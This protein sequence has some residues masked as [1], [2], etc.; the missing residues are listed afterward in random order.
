MRRTVK[1]NAINRKLTA[2][3]KGPR[4]VLDRIQIPT[5]DWFFSPKLNELYHYDSGVFEA[6]PA[7]DDTTFHTYHTIK[8]LP[9]DVQLVDVECIPPHNRW[10]ILRTLPHATTFWRDIKSQDKLEAHLLD[11]NRRHLE[12]TSREGGIS[13]RLPLTLVRQNYGIN[14]L[15]EQIL[16]GSFTT[17]YDLSPEMAAFFDALKSTPATTSLPP[18]LGAINSAQFQKMFQLSKEKTSSDIRTLNYSL[19]KCIATSDRI[20]QYAAILV[21]LPFMY[22]FVNTHWTHM[23]DF[24]LEKKPGVRQIHQLRIIGKVP[25]EFNTCLKFYIGHQTMHNFEN[26]DPCDDQHG[27][28]PNR[29]SI[30]AGLLK[31]LTFECARMQR[32]T[33]CMVQHDMTA[34]FDRMYPA[35]TSIYA[36]RYNVDRNILLSIGK[37]IH[38]L[39]RNVETALGISTASYKQLPNAPEIGGMVQGKADVP[40]LSMQQSDAMLKAHKTLTTGLSLPNPNG[41]RIITH[42]SVSFADD[43]DNPTNK[44]TS[45]PN[46]ILQAVKTCE[47]SAQIW[48]N[49]V[50]ICGGLIALHKCNWQIIAWD[51]SSGRMELLK[52]PNTVLILRNGNGTPTIIDYFP[53]D[54]PNVGLGFLLCPDGSQ[55]PQ[56]RNLKTAINTL[57]GRIESSFLNESET[58]QALTQRLLPKLNY[59]LHTTTLNRLQCNRINSIIC[60]TFLPRMRLNRHFPWAVLYAPIKYGG[61]AFPEVGA[62]QLSTQLE[63][64]IKQLRWNRIMANTLLVTIETIQLHTGVGPPL[65]ESVSPPIQYAGP[66]LIL[67][68][69][70]RL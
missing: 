40:Q 60:S 24:M 19:W 62:I 58:R 16:D 22:G 35:M 26:A 33:M 15:T 69:R 42:H 68:I 54:K 18:V 11:H 3:V 57:C 47:K 12:Q 36:S 8:I 64:F 46:P 50:N 1:T 21:S 2:I 38:W 52:D 55:T 56:F 14:P 32:S 53:P 49:L 39:K 4:G 67:S 17:S 13:T 9:D 66:S 31:L 5:H 41:S 30:D 29:S 51:G 44:D 70:D 61:M 28:R 48:S 6:Y 10:T 63:Y 45:G 23:S 37:T 59:V 7:F 65:L 43:T 34:H 25:A 20:S 27:F